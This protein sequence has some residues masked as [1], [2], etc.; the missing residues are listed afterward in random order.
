MARIAFQVKTNFNISGNWT[1]EENNQIAIDE[2]RAVW[3]RRIADNSKAISKAALY[4]L[5]DFN[6]VV[7]NCNF[8]IERAYN[9]TTIIDYATL[10]NLITKCQLMRI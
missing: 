2:I 5:H 6:R 1:S 4:V 9:S 10:S 8:T 7:D 3:L